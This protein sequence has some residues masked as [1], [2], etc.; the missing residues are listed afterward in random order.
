VSQAGGGPPDEH[1]HV[2]SVFVSV[3][4][5]VTELGGFVATAADMID[6]LGGDVLQCA[7]GDK[8]VV[9]FAV[10]GAPVAHADDAARAVHAIERLRGLTSVDF[11][12]GIASGLAFPAAFG[13]RSRIFLGALGRTT[14]L[15]ARL[16]SAAGKG[17]DARGR[18][19]GRRTARAGDAPRH[20]AEV[21]EGDH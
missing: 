9:L 10:F 14:N 5:D 1:R 8:G 15:A 18:A 12:A 20:R 17:R 6:E 7:G 2:T 11:A 16:M 4:P 19:N 3:P 21:A 13:G